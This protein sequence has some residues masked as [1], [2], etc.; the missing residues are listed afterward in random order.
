MTRIE[1]IIASIR[2]T[3][4]NTIPDREGNSQ[5]ERNRTTEND[6]F[7]ELTPTQK[8]N[9]Q[10][11]KEIL[12]AQGRED[13]I[14]PESNADTTPPKKGL[15]KYFSK[16]SPEDIESDRLELIKQNEAKQAKHDFEQ[17]Q[18][19]ERIRHHQPS[20]FEEDISKVKKSISDVTAKASNKIV[21]RAA[22]GVKQIAKGAK[23][24][25]VIAAPS[26]KKIVSGTAKSV[27]PIINQ[28]GKGMAEIDKEEK[29]K[30]KSTLFRPP[31][32]EKTPRRLMKM[33]EG[34]DDYFAYGLSKKMPSEKSTKKK[35]SRPSR[36][37]NDEFSINS[38]RNAN[39]T[40]YNDDH[41]VKKAQF[42]PKNKDN[43]KKSMKQSSGADDYFVND[44]KKTPPKQ[45]TKGKDRRGFGLGF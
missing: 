12:I 40:K 37:D 27:A 33:S 41:F 16:R 6:E 45:E 14:E 25:A 5:K 1:H 18:K 10:T 24:T 42:K 44:R 38:R 36:N 11:Y 39:P 35:S 4:K 34:A 20:R 15:S 3:K 17:E 28:M 8:Q 31:R 9:N 32:E 13:L 30:P 19:N 2:G 21:A 29:T 23:R 7:I 26:V 22:K 43:P